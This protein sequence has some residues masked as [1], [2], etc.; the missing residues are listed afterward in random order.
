MSGDLNTMQVYTKK[1]TLIA[2]KDRE[3][4]DKKTGDMLKFRSV[5]LVDVE[6]G[7][8]VHVNVGQKDRQ[9]CDFRPF[10]SQTGYATFQLREFAGQL[11][12]SMIGFETTQRSFDE[13]KVKVKK[14]A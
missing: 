9:L 6:D 2:Q 14:T 7:E 12:V 10:V 8:D 3:G 1:V 5:L 4:K 13:E 11:K